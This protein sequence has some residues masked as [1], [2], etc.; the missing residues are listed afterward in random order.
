[1]PYIY[2]LA[3]QTYLNDYTIMRGM[4]MDFPDDEN[5]LDINDQFM[6]GPS[7]LVNPVSEYKARNRNV[8]LPANCGWYDFFTGKYYDGGQT[9]NADAPYITDS[10]FC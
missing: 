3:G 4:V 10:C 9:I 8:Y 7:L 2:S 1:M 5:V 6:F